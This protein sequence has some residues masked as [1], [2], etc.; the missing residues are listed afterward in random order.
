MVTVVDKNARP[1]PPRGTSRLLRAAPIDALVADLSSV[2]PRAVERCVHLV[3]NL[4]QHNRASVPVL[5]TVAMELYAL[6][7]DHDI[8]FDRL[9]TKA[10]TDPNV[11]ARIMGLASSPHYGMQ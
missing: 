7:A 6:A 4:E 2:E 11:A 8:P 3:T 10:V 1:T 9:A 5:P